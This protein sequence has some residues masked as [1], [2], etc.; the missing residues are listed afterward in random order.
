MIVFPLFFNWTELLYR[1]GD[2]VDSVR[3]AAMFTIASIFIFSHFA[4]R[5]YD[6]FGTTKDLTSKFGSFLI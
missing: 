6:Q 3:F 5:L 4:Y 2:S 1:L